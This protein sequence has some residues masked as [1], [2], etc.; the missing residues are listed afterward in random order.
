MPRGV[1]GPV[2]PKKRRETAAQ[3]VLTRNDKVRIGFSAWHARDDHDIAG[4]G[5]E[6]R[7]L[8]AGRKDA[9]P[10]PASPSSA[11]SNRAA[12]SAGPRFCESVD[13][14]GFCKTDS[15]GMSAGAIALSGNRLQTCVW[16]SSGMP[17]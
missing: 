6:A 4:L 16:P 1:P 11:S 10:R 13:C 12:R 5:V 17:R 14:Q 3:S 7:G 2:S 8:G 15:L 9:Q